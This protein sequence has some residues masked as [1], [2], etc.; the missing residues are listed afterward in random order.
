MRVRIQITVI[1][2]CVYPIYFIFLKIED[3]FLRR[4]LPKISHLQSNQLRFK[5]ITLW[6]QYPSFLNNIFIKKVLYTHGTK[7]KGIKEHLV[8]SQCPSYLCLSDKQ[9]PSQKYHHYQF[10]GKLLEIHLTQKSI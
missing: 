7:F 3:T 1:F 8:K 2:F 9:F 10:L 6:Q 5:H 4:N